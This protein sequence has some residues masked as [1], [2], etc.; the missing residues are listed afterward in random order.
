MNTT[1]T[2]LWAAQQ[3]AKIESNIRDFDARRITYDEFHARQAS[4]WNEVNRGE[5]NVIGTA[6]CRRN[7]AVKAA[8]ARVMLA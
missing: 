1:T 5:P 2:P 7:L 3:A 8:L 6:C 4:V